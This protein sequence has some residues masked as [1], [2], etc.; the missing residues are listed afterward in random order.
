MSIYSVPLEAVPNQIVST[1]INGQTWFIT[2]ETRLDHLYI[3]F[4]TN[5]VDVCFNRVCENLNWVYDNFLF[6]DLEGTTDPQWQ[7]LSTRY[8]LLWT[9]EEFVLQSTGTADPNPQIIKK[10]YAPTNIII[11]NDINVSWTARGDYDYMNYYRSTSPLDVDNMPPPIARTNNTFY[12]DNGMEA[13]TT[14]YII[15]STVL[16]GIEKFSEQRINFYSAMFLEANVYQEYTE[17]RTVG[18]AKLSVE[19]ET[20]LK[21]NMFYNGNK[22]IGTAEPNATIEIE[23]ED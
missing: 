5:G 14:Y 7:G 6:A 18:I 21:A 22:L 9:D 13:D 2:V 10:S 16:N 15:V 8:L 11:T 4:R 1:T 12:V 20:A 3:S 17:G 23:V 19:V